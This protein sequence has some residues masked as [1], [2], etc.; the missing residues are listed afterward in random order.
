MRIGTQVPIF[1]AL[2]TPRHLVIHQR[3]IFILVILGH[4]VASSPFRFHL[5]CPFL[6]CLLAF[7]PNALRL[8]RRCRPALHTIL[9]HRA[10]CLGNTKYQNHQPLLRK[11][12][13]VDEIGIDGILEIAALVVWEQDIDSLRA[14]VT[15]VGSEFRTG[16]R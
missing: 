6:I 4:A 7:S 2:L 3:L 12:G 16:F 5:H 14:W 11:L 1:N 8:S 9:M 10:E 13:M 15:A